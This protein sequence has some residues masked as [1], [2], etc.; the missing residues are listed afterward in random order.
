MCPEVESCG[1]IGGRELVDVGEQK[2][3]DVDGT[4]STLIPM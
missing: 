2:I 1:D 4:Y 3:L